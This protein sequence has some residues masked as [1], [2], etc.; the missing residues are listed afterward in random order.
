VVLGRE[1]VRDKHNLGFSNTKRAPKSKGAESE[2]I[3]LA[4]RPLATS[5]GNA[6]E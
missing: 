4:V 6:G 5:R 2:K 1:L 3:A